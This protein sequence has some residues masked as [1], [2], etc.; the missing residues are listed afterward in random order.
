MS[1]LLP[2]WIALIAVVTAVPV[3]A[4]VTINLTTDADEKNCNKNGASP[5]LA[6]DV[7]G[8]MPL[9]PLSQGCS[10]REAI[11]NI[12]NGTTTAFPECTP[13]PETGPAANNVIDLGG[14]TIILNSA[15]PDPVTG[16]TTYNG[17]IPDI[18]PS[19]SIGKL[20]IQ[21]GT[22]QCF[23]DP[24]SSDGI[25]MFRVVGGDLTLKNLSASKCTASVPGIV[26]Q[27]DSGN[28]TLTNVTVG[29]QLI[30]ANGI[31]STDGGMGG[32]IDHGSGN[33]NITDSTFGNCAIDTKGP[34]KG[35]GG[36]L[37]IGIVGF[38][39]NAA[40]TNVVFTSNTAGESGGAI[41]LTST[42]ALSLVNSAFTNNTANGDTFVA[43][44]AEIGG[45]AIFGSTTATGGHTLPDVPSHFLI[46]GTIFTANS[47]PKGT[48]GAILI[49]SGNLN[50]AQALPAPPWILPPGPGPVPPGTNISIPGGVFDS[51]FFNNSAGGTWNGSPID[52][53]AGA[54]GAIFVHGM[55][56]MLDSSLINNSGSSGGGVALYGSNS[57]A[58]FGN[59]TFNGNSAN[60]NGGAV[61]NLRNSA[62]NFNGIL[63]LANTTISGNSA[64][65]NGGGALYNGGAKADAVVANSILA[66]S[67]AGG[68]CAG[69]NGITDQT[70]NLQFGSGT[71]CG[72]SITVGDPMLSGSAP[73]GG[74][75]F[76]VFVMQ[77]NNGSAASG[78]GDAAT[79][80]NPPVY[81]LDAALNSRPSGKPNC[82]IGAF[83]SGIAPDL[84][85]AKTHADPFIS[86]STGDTYTITVSNSGNDS[87]TGTVAV[88]D[89][90]PAGLTATA[91]SGSSWS[92]TLGS[93]T[94]TR[95]DALA[96]GSSYPPVTLTVDVDPGLSGL[97]VN[98]AAVSGGGEA[99]TGNDVANDST[100][101]VPP[102]DLTI[103][104]THSG[105][106]A[107]GQVGATFTITVSNVGSGPTSGTVSVVDNLPA[108]L[109]ATAISGTGWICVLGTLTC[110][111]SD[112]LA[113]APAAYPPI[114]VTVDV[115]ANPPAQV[116]NSADVSGGG[117]GNIGNNHVDDGTTL[118]VRLQSFEVD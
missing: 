98:S 100:N 61:A 18:F 74:V 110:T 83:E 52:T 47:A 84:T 116:I 65:S 95:S 113:A 46:L 72:A 62:D 82:D 117:D 76:A 60:V 109:T 41:Y 59:V 102:P 38:S 54:G 93:L 56:D 12:D 10:L 64:G 88:A 33:L 105:N 87:T 107:K 63:S 75:N 96:A 106:F 4:T 115:A 17:T 31:H 70:H 79:C 35:Y 11:A 15:V 37:H 104:K 3:H 45:G 27:N 69:P 103:A 24:V 57:T 97:I 50:L 21:N 13:A 7:S 6:C 32:C 8:D 53:R 94:C 2:R 44:N 29:D 66:S 43:G 16:I 34:T 9:P 73:F 80:S 55:L 36:A 58:Y 28:T 49:S 114:T 14:R 19:S 86:P 112:V 42:D 85:V 89:S 67:S 48:G 23:V 26:V 5:N 92:C 91:M 118:P 81:D 22:V 90:L 71:D 39:T 1:A 25:R 40:L 30:S 99:N 78:N 108:G 101:L 111:R 77:L 68:N 20:T 51:Q